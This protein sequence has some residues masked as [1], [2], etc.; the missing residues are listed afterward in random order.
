VVTTLYK[1]TEEAKKAAE[2]KLGYL[3]KE[4]YSITM[5]F[6][7]PDEDG[8][9]FYWRV[10]LDH[11]VKGKEIRPISFIDRK[12][13]AKEPKFPTGKPLYNLH[14]ISNRPDETIWIVEGEKCAEALIER[15]ILATT[16]GSASSAD[17]ADWSPIYG[18]EI[19]CW[20]DNDESGFQYIQNIKNIL[21][22]KI[23]K[24]NFVDLNHI[25]LP[26]KGDCVDWLEKHPD[27]DQ[28]DIERLPLIGVNAFDLAFGNWEEPVLPQ[29][30]SPPDIPASLLPEP[31]SEYAE[32]LAKSIEVPEGLAVLGILGTVS[33]AISH[34][35]KV[36]PKPGWEES[37]N[38]YILA[39][40]PPGN[41]KSA[42]L[43]ACTGPL[44]DWEK[45][46]AESMGL[47]IKKD[48]SRRKTMEEQIKRRRTVAI[49]EKDHDLQKREFHEIDEM[50][51]TLEEVPAL[52]QIF[53]TDATPESLAKSIHEQGGR[54]AVICDEGGIID[55]ISGL[56]TKG[57]ANINIVL[58]GIDGGA[59]R[60]KRQES[61]IDIKP[62]L[63]FCLFVQPAIL[64][65]MANQKSLA[66][67]GLRE[68]FLY[69]VPETKLGYRTHDTEPVS[70]DIKK[71][72]AFGISEL[73][74]LCMDTEL[75]AAKYWLLKLSP[76][77]SSEFRVFHLQIEKELRPEGKLHAISGWGGKICGFSLRIAGLMHVMECGVGDGEICS[78]TMG[79]AIVLAHLLIEHALIAFDEMGADQ[80]AEDA[81]IIFNW[82]KS[83]GQC[84][85]KKNDCHR[86]LGSRFQY[87]RQ[88]E[89][90]LEILRERNIVSDPIFI[91]TGGKGRP[92][93][94]YRAN[95]HLFVEIN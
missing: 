31:F 25:D 93:I 86:E 72:Y 68:R 91:D 8:N 38:L 41:N 65:N 15:G 47:E 59:V 54:F 12:W 45:K 49:R 43:K 94:W 46:Q 27:S 11:P 50:E 71:E 37:T 63:T 61:S 89:D 82:I 53:A 32:V 76:D 48:Q 40:L 92:S 74:E 84:M 95:P 1:T 20:P 56:Y 70:P 73:L 88:L 67:K 79:R 39:S 21:I 7:Y 28:S 83:N 66:G 22:I 42:A 2:E 58:S 44:T 52:P 3:L 55:V 33:S 85:F 51:S 4:G 80:T 34:R 17:G 62:I 13:E 35:V 6:P 60:I 18:R 30:Y 19:V 16:S 29:S 81:K 75:E 26:E 69:F 77:A 78:K 9:L 87:V 23:L 5:L 57:Q 64:Q 24:I 14:E 36:S 10:R 90:A